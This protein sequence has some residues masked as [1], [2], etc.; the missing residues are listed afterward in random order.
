MALI[1]RAFDTSNGKSYIGQS[2]KTLEERRDEHLSSSGPYPFL[3]A[4]KK[5]A[6]KFEWTVLL[7]GIENQ[8]DLD[9]AEVKC[10]SSLDT[11][12][13]KGYNLQMGGRGGRHHQI[14]RLK[15]S[16]SHKGKKL[17]K[18]HRNKIGKAH[19]GSKRTEESRRRMSLAQQNRILSEESLSKMSAGRKGKS[20][21]PLSDETKRKM[22]ESH[23]GMIFSDDHR[24]KLSESAKGRKFSAD[25]KKKLSEAA[26]K[27]WTDRALNADIPAS[28][29]FRRDGEN[30]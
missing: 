21:G 24:R 27:R 25:H 29:R 15:M 20:L 23:K 1:Y 28:S 17:S 6:D 12:W 30:S 18:E 13:P 7:E 9:E 8:K 19:L 11:L 5:R 10:I 26:K 22:S 3:R 2:W 16:N 14:S 4:L